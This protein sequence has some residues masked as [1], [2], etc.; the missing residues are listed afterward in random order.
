MNALFFHEITK[1]SDHF[2]SKEAHISRD[3]PKKKPRAIDI[4][5]NSIY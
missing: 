2:T 3:V 5:I 4:N 1:H